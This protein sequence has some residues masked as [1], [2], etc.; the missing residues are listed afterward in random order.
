[1]IGGLAAAF[2]LCG[3]AV[4]AWH[5]RTLVW[6][7]RVSTYDRMGWLNIPFG[8]NARFGVDAATPTAGVVVCSGLALVGVLTAPEMMGVSF[9]WPQAVIVVLG[10]VVTVS[11]LGG[12]LLGLSLLLF[13]FP[14]FLAP[15]D[16]RDQRGWIPEWLHQTS[17]KRAERPDRP[18][19]S[20]E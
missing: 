19:R 13:M 15:P 20:R 7:D 2:F 12:M 11:V 18:R 16:L 9:R 5:V 3:T 4:V 6:R 10:P 1:M 17:L 8:E 14:R